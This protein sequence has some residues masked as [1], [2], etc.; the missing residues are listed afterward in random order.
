MN[1]LE[2][3]YRLLDVGAEATAEEIR[4][5][6]LVL[7]NVWHPDR[8]A[9]D[10]G[11][12]ARALE[13]LKAIND[14][15]Q[16]I[17]LAPLQDHARAARASPPP[18][19]VPRR[20]DARPES[21]PPPVR[22]AAEWF[23][24][25]LRLANKNVEMPPGESL[26]WSNIA[27]LTQ[28]VEG[29]RAY[30]EALRLNPDFAEAWYSLG[31]A[32][33]QFHQYSE[34]THAFREAV[35]LRPGQ[36]SAWINLGTALAQLQKYAEVIQAFRQAV[37]LNARDAAAWYTLGVAYGHP[38]IRQYHDAAEA[39][40]EAVRLRPELAEAWYALGNVCLRLRAEGQAGSEDARAAF[41][42]AVT[43]KPDLAEAWYGLGTTLSGLGRHGEAIGALR[44]AVRL[45][46]DSVEAWFSLG[47]ASHLAP[48]AEA[49]RAVEEAYGHLR[50]LDRR[51]AS[52][53]LE[54]LPRHQRLWLALRSE[55]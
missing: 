28:H 21:P 8:F 43:L 10:P 27:N 31:L 40:R 52:R 34:A 2:E 50:R 17:K 14:A 30:Q 7:V 6:Y 32:H 47:V 39:Y 55:G 22:S 1:Q 5:A 25:G 41:R 51:E 37:R 16:R 38:Q 53:F 4:G 42:E 44:Q 49:G 3:C 13:K 20:P 9:H 45:Q 24:L 35:R 12:Q 54:T 19:P 29:I 15:F 23:Q 18:P 36:A 11:L 46:P 33:A 26:S 48:R